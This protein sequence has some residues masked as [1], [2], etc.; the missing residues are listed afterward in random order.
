MEHRLA[1]IFSADAA[2]YT[3]LLADDQPATIRA[4]AEAR[5]LF[6]HGVE[7]HHGRVIDTAGD[8]VLAE[9]PSALD[10][11]RASVE[12]QR[13]LHE[14]AAAQPEERRLLFRIGLH[15]GDI[16]AEAER[17][18][19]DGVNV[20]AR[21]QTLAE[22]GGI[23]LSAAIHDN[24]A[25]RLDLPFADIG[26]Q[27]LKNFPRPVRAFRLGG[28]APPAAV[29]A[30]PEPPDRPSLVVLPFTN[31]SGDAEQE[32]FADGMSEDLITELAR[33]P[34]LFVIGRGTSFAYKG[35]SVAARELGRELG[36]RH[37]VEGS[38]RRA[39]SRVRITARLTETKSGEE[40]WSER[41]DRE[42]GDVF[43]L[44]DEVVGG[45]VA[46]LQRALGAGLEHTPRENAVRPEVWELLV[47]GRAQLQRYT[48][49]SGPASRELLL[50]CVALDPGFA[51]G[52]AELA[53]CE[54]SLHLLGMEND[55]Y[56]E[57]GFE[58]VRHALELDPEEPVAHMTL[59]LLLSMR[60]EGEAAVASARR[61]LELTP[62]DA[63]LRLHFGMLLLHASRPEEAISVL[64]NLTRLDPAQRYMHLFQLA[65]CYKRLGRTDEAIA[66]HRECLAANPDFFGAHMQLAAIHA[67]LGEMNQARASLAEVMRLRPD[68]SIARI[69]R[70]G[71]RE[72]L[73][74]NLRKA[75]LRE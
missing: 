19:G 14:G 41:Y 74:E 54:Q 35:K 57:R 59:G 5:D 50:R 70:V 10:A 71:R 44:Q 38:V 23:C 13:A 25:G 31:V 15:L 45:V 1:A 21:L 3:R 2:G 39:G 7:R 52:W 30:P 62:G 22:P 20:A 67:E 47:Q 48:P 66:K 27:S 6:T 32:Y 53:R 69:P 36:V 18:Y 58:H 43:A 40:I 28:S 73:I 11:V 51:L 29:A 26:E 4:L 61:S 34:S 17:I 9:F 16:A 72:F 12:L 46:E 60:G 75:G 64:K 24:V 8:N 63:T 65:L 33:I 42:L 56:L 49:E 37:V 68:F 55:A